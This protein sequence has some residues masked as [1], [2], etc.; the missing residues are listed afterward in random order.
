MA[1]A[2]RVSLESQCR[3]KVGRKN[4]E[5]GS[6]LNGSTTNPLFSSAAGLVAPLEK[7][8]MAKLVG[9]LPFTRTVNV[10][11]STAEKAP[12]IQWTILHV[13]RTYESYGR[14]SDLLLEATCWGQSS[15]G[16]IFQI[17]RTRLF[18]NMHSRFNAKSTM[19][20]VSGIDLKRA[21]K[22]DI[23]F[24]GHSTQ[25]TRL[26]LSAFLAML[27][28]LSSWKA[29]PGQEKTETQNRVCLPLSVNTWLPGAFLS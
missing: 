12:V 1:R 8:I 29:W 26:C 5:R 2:R 9:Q 13:V 10:N 20:C 6:L 21:N 4:R 3:S 16:L 27:V 17:F 22:P 11:D 25:P 23:P 28:S 14:V 19:D 18:T 15:T 7:L 24:A